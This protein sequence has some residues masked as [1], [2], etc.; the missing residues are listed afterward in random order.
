MAQT[1]RARRI[2]ADFL[3][4]QMQMDGIKSSMLSQIFHEE[5]PP[6]DTFLYDPKYLNHLRPTLPSPDESGYPFKLSPIQWEFV[7]NFEQIFRPEL[8]IAMVEEFG[9]YW[10]PLPMKNMFVAAWGKGSGKDTTVRIGF[11]RLASLLQHLKSPQGYFNM[12]STD[13]IHFLNV[14]ATAPQARRAFFDPMKK[15]FKNNKHLSEFFYGDDPAEGANQIRLKNDIYIIS[16]NSMAENQE[17]LN[18][19]AGVAD[20]ISAFKVAEEF[21]D[22]GGGRQNRGAEAIVSF[23]RSSSSSRFPDTYKVAQISF[24][25]FQ[26]DAIEK[27]MAQGRESLKANGVDSQWYVSGPHATWEV[28]PTVTKANFKEHYE[29]DPEMAMTMYECKPPKSTNT[30]IRNE[31]AIDSAFETVKKEPIEVE[32]Y[33]GLPPDRADVP[34]GLEA[35]EGWQV[36]F[37]YSDDFYP[38]PGALYAMHGDMAIKGDRAGIAMSHVS[39]WQNSGEDDER[40]IITNDFV[41]TFESDLSDREHPREVQI[42]WYRQLIWELIDRGFPIEIVTYDQFQSFDM[43]QTLNTYG[44]DSGLLSLD[45]NDKVYQTVKDVILDGRLSGYR[46]DPALD[47]LVVRELKRLR[48]VGKKVDHLPGQSKDAADALA[49][50]VYNAIELGGEED[51]SE[52]NSADAMYATSAMDVTMYTS[53]HDRAQLEQG[54]FG[55]FAMGGMDNPFSPHGGGSGGNLFEPPSH[56]Y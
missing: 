31:A 42:R 36:Q 48:R 8:Y 40:P 12:A 16:G 41:F 56:R 5:P 29:E 52:S 9:E 17:G 6:L 33:W 55:G 14:A 23:L 43:V 22:K 13:P 54:M 50:S 49:G 11:T 10:A 46:T 53:S 4:E 26:G 21:R 32:Y 44:I 38:I 51:A 35:R 24:P 2:A 34:D 47:P 25:R 3:R 15:L 27:A 7:R 20:E 19:L 37:R 45:R 1:G 28:K 18:I 30:F 39:S